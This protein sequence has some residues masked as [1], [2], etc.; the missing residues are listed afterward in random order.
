MT[1]RWSPKLLCAEDRKQ[2][3]N[4]RK[5]RAL[6]AGLV[7]VA[8]M[9]GINLQASL[10]NGGFETGNFSGWALSGDTGADAFLISPSYGVAHS[11]TYG[12]YAGPYQNPINPGF[13]YIAQ[14]L[15]TV[16]GQTYHMSFWLRT[17][18][19]GI[20]PQVPPNQFVALW[21]GVQVA[22]VLDAYTLPW[23]EYSVNV[24]A[25][26]SSTE[27]KFGFWHPP[28]GWGFDD[29]SVSPVPEPTTMIAGALLLLPF[30]ASTLRV[31]RKSRLA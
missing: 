25:T 9:S 3:E 10:V 31:L 19:G 24:V 16:A 27:L 28:A 18:D 8:V 14:T 22:S 21:G 15:A 12:L 11:G 17:S 29:V 4:M 30:G 7:M 2:K 26:G 6:G 23:A 13:G 1:L 20:N 5:I